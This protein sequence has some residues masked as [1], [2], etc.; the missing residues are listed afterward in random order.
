M[1]WS[2]LLAQHHRSAAF[3]P[4]WRSGSLPPGFSLSDELST[5][6]DATGCLYGAIV[7]MEQWGTVLAA[8]LMIT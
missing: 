7:S 6:G 1:A 5:A 8:K 2:A 3:I 4:L